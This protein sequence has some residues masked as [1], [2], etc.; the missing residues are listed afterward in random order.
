MHE[1]HLIQPV[2]D[3]LSQH[4]KDEGAKSV[5]KVCL[6]VGQL[7]GTTEESFK[8]TFAVLAKDTILEGADVEIVFFPGSVVKVISFDVE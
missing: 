2:I 3:G 7:I 6:R 5:K 8:E 4:A 1:T